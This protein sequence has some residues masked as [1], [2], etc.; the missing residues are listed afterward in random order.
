MTALICFKHI[1]HDGYM[2]NSVTFLAIL[3]ACGQIE[4]GKRGQTTH[5]K[6]LKEGLL[7]KDVSLGNAL[8]DM[9]AKCG[10]LGRAQSVFDELLL[11]NIV[12]WTSLIGGYAEYGYGKE[13][14]N[15]LESMKYE[16]FSPDAITF[17]SLLNACSHSGMVNEAETYYGNM[18]KKYGIAPNLEH[19]TSMVIIYCFEGHFDK[20]MSVMKMMP[21]CDYSAV[22][23]VLVD[24]CRKWG[25][26]K[27]GSW[28]FEHSLQVNIDC[29]QPYVLTT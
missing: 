3:K 23:F 26:M 11:R 19:H 27:L 1:Q 17:V 22:W 4:A 7:E 2:P 28:A 9:Y 15:C 6:I 29:M 12:S 24:S 13:A 25:N 10:E 20:A 5:V 14:L 18:S 16:G 8:V 21:S